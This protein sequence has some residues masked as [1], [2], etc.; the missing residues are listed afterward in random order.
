M[1]KNNLVTV[2]LC[3]TIDFSI[4]GLITE[5]RL[6]SQ[7]TPTPYKIKVDNCK[8]IDL[9][10]KI[11]LT[12]AILIPRFSN[13]LRNSRT[14]FRMFLYLKTCFLRVTV[15]LKGGDMQLPWQQLA[16]IK[17][18]VVYRKTFLLFYLIDFLIYF[19]AMYCE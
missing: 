16:H 15:E 6:V 19:I 4:N 8:F 7:R 9:V 17:K 10:I 11:E 14:H 2:I 3:V 13:F 18:T 12:R 1:H 5:N